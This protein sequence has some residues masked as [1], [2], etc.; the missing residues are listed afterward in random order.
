[1]LGVVL[2]TNTMFPGTLEWRSMKM[3]ML[4]TEKA[5]E[6]LRG[7]VGDLV[8]YVEGMDIGGMM[9]GGGRPGGNWTMTT[10]GLEGSGAGLGGAVE[11]G[12][13]AGQVGGM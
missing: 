9:G 13:E 11:S 7:K 5:V 12:S 8:R 3:E 6:V 2:F 1:M 4:G 10:G